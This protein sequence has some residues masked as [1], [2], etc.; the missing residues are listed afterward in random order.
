MNTYLVRFAFWGAGNATTTTN[1]CV[2]IDVS[3]YLQNLLNSGN[4]VITPSNSISNPPFPDP[5][6]GCTKGFGAV[7]NVNGVDC[8]FA[9]QENQTIDFSITPLR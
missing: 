4:V 5:A 1:Q 7:V 6:V 9:C 8:Y 2:A 3:L